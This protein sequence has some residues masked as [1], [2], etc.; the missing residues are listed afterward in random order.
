VKLL[1]TTAMGFQRKNISLYLYAD[2]MFYK[3]AVPGK[4]ELI[5]GKK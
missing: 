1:Y 2:H 4:G 3:L 5:K